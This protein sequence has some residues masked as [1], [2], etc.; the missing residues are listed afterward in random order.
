M[1]ELM[2]TCIPA[3]ARHGFQTSIATAKWLGLISRHVIAYL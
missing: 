2:M 1:H 3:A